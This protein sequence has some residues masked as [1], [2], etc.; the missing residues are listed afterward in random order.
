[1]VRA[2]IHLGFAVKA[3]RTP[4]EA[5]SVMQGLATF[6]SPPPDWLAR[7]KPTAL[8]AT[9]WAY[10]ERASC[11]TN[12]PLSRIPFRDHSEDLEKGE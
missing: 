9:R 7:V 3:V 2:T 5:N 6:Q 12:A 1:M 11:E 8:V 10:P 4:H